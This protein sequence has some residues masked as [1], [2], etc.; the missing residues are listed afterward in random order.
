MPEITNLELLKWFDENKAHYEIIRS[1]LQSVKRRFENADHETRRDMLLASYE[2]AVISVQTPVN[3][4]EKAWSAIREGADPEDAMQQVNYWRNKLDYMQRTQVKFEL[5]DDVIFNLLDGNIDKAHKIL[6]D[7]FLGV[8]AKKAGFTLAMLGYTSKMCIDTNVEQ[9]AGLDDVYS[10]V[11]VDKYE[12]QCNEV[13]Q[14]YSIN[15]PFMLQWIL[16][17]C[18]RGETTTHNVYFSHQLDIERTNM[19]NI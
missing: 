10:G 14:E 11:V 17:D 12:D 3:I 7:E 1:R 4:H 18:Y 2:F 13:M 15:T 19:E 9:A 6:I 16:F 8:G 5:I